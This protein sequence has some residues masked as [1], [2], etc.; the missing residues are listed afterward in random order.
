[1][2]NYVVRHPGQQKVLDRIKALAARL[3]ESIAAG[4]PI[5][6]YGTPGTGKDHLVAALLHQATRKHGISAAFVTALRFAAN[7]RAQF[8]D[9]ADE[10]YTP[11]RLVKY[12][13]LAISD[14]IPPSGDMSEW[15]RNELH[16]L[17]D[18]RY[19]CLR[20]TWV[21]LNMVSEDEIKA[22]LTMQTFD[23]LR[24]VGHLIPCLWPSYRQGDSS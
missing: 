10:R 12:G 4:E 6:L 7:C 13:V 15:A 17:I 3:P 16:D 24:H 19:R 23:R 9:E 21:T 22:K 2:G 20:P 18:A 11:A 5:L 14:P 1:L 8:R